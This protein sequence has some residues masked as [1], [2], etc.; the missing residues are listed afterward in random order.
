V[1]KRD[2]SIGFERAAD[3]YEAARPSYPTEVAA[4]VDGDV[5]LD[6][7]AGTGKLTRVLVRDGRTVI[8]IEPVDA[9]RRACAAHAPVAGGTAELLP[10]RSSSVD[11]VTVGQG[12]HWFDGEPAL[13]EIARVLRPD[14]LLLLVWNE[15]DTTAPWVE[16]MSR[17]VHAH[18]PGEATA[19]VKVDDWSV[20]IDAV[21]L[22]GPVT[23]HAFPFTHPATHQ[24]FVERALSTSYIASA[25]DQVRA[26]VASDVAAAVAHLE[27]P[28][29]FPHVADVY[30]CRK[31]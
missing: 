16:A 12:F 28:F 8:G 9:M 13:R 14:G 4:L 6:L 22:F 3:L 7:A 2:A 23:K 21:D 18:D 10:V 25:S 24:T 17:I 31:R 20:V 19:Y 1:I 11:A 15:R 5:V 27:E 30:T 29:D 26:Q